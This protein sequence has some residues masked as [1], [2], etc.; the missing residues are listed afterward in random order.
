MHKTTRRRSPSP[1]RIL[2]ARALVAGAVAFAAALAAGGPAAADVIF[3]FSPP[4]TGVKRY[5]MVIEAKHSGLDLNV[6]EASTKN[7]TQII[8]WNG[9]KKFMNGQWEMLPAG[10][11]RHTFRN[12][13][14]RQCLDVTSTAAGAPVVQ[15]PCD[16]TVSQKWRRDALT[17]TDS[18]IT[19]VWSELDLN[20]EG[21]STALGAKLIQWPRTGG[22]NAI[23]TITG[24]N[25]LQVVE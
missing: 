6:P 24:Y 21:G 16:G 8:Q 3:D 14:S 20:V 2:R 17:S 12:R 18:T 15:R 13:W 25:E 5:Y 23:F 1:F 4:Y 22:D 10:N 9:S 11:G 7:D 19:N